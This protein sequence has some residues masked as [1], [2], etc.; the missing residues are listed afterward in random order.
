MPDAS[1][2]VELSHRVVPALAGPGRIVAMHKAKHIPLEPGPGQL[3]LEVADN[4]RVLGQLVAYL[5]AADKY[6]DPSRAV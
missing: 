4:D 6:S 5:L 2:L 3:G 1:G